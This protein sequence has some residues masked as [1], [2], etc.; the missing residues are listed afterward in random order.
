MLCFIAIL[1][2]HVT[3]VTNTGFPFLA[4]EKVSAWKNRLRFI[5]PCAEITFFTVRMFGWSS[6]DYSDD[7]FDY[8]YIIPQRL[9]L[10]RSF[11][12]F[13]RFA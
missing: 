12:C 13:R 8:I 6:N 9:P 10:F 5:L 3:D 1:L 7:Y 11:C 2:I 4:N